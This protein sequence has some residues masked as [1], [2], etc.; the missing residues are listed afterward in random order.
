[1]REAGYALRDPHIWPAT[2][3]LAVP[4]FDGAGPAASLG[5]T[6]F[7][8]TMKPQ[9][10]ADRFLPGLQEIAARVGDRLREL[11]AG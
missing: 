2:N 5:M 3:T 7:S 6:F 9:Q 8:S 1:V 11:Q 4:V 10:A